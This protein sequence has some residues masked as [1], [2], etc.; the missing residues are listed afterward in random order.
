MRTGPK[1]R[2]ATVGVHYLEVKRVGHQKPNQNAYAQRWVQSLQQECLDRFNVF[3]PDH[4]QHIVAQYVE[5]YNEGR[6]YQ[7]RD[8][9]PLSIKKAI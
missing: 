5:H 3:A 2:A 7:A 8:N 1:G 9:L 6:S 4:L